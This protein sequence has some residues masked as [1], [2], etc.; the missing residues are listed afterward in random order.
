MKA[1]EMFEELGYEKYSRFN[2]GVKVERNI[3]EVNF[4]KGK[5]IVGY[6]YYVFENSTKTICH[7][8]S[9]EDNYINIDELKAINKQVEEL[10]WNE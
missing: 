4:L 10:G 7:N 5:H 8:T 2:W 1:R 9:C 6:E 3:Y